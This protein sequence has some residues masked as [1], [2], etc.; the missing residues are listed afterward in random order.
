MRSAIEAGKRQPPLDLRYLKNEEI[1][2]DQTG[3]SVR[4]RVITFLEQVYNSQAETLPDTRDDAADEALGVFVQ[5]H[6]LKE[7]LEGMPSVDIP[8]S[9]Q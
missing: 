7:A 2:K 9:A 3:D 5:D 6:A 4:A 8:K 1:C